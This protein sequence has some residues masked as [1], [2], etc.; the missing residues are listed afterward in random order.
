[1][2]KIEDMINKMIELA[3]EIDEAEKR[4]DSTMNRYSLSLIHI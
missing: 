4:G 1:M 2:D 3:R